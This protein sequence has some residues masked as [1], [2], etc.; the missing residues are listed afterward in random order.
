M[1]NL[2]IYWKSFKNL[3][4]ELDLKECES[5][6]QLTKGNLDGLL[7]VRNLIGELLKMHIQS[8]PKSVCPSCYLARTQSVHST[9][10]YIMLCLLLLLLLLCNTFLAS[11]SS[12]IILIMHHPHQPSS[13]ST[14]IPI[15]HHP[16]HASSSISSAYKIVYKIFV[17]NYHKTNQ[18]QG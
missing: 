14:I 1:L 12:H 8:R 9:S 5:L 4:W 2:F 13:S 16:N 17:W 7:K 15:N 18:G 10:I 3:L 6:F 11:S